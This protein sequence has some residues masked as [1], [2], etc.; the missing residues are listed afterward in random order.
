MWINQLNFYNM[1]LSGNGTGVNIK[2]N[3]G[4]SLNN[5]TFNCVGFE[6]LNTG[7]SIDSKNSIA[8]DIMFNSCRAQEK[9]TTFINATGKV[10]NVLWNGS[11]SLL[12]SNMLNV[13]ND[14]DNWIF[15]NDN[16]IIKILKGKKFNEANSINC[17]GGYK[18]T[19]EDLNTITDIGAYVCQYVDSKNITN[20]PT[21]DISFRLYV[22]EC[23]STNTHDYDFSIMQIYTSIQG[24]FIRYITKLNNE[25]TV[26]K[27]HS[28]NKKPSYSDGTATS[29][30][31]ITATTDCIVYYQ[32]KLTQGMTITINGNDLIYYN[33][34]EPTLIS[35][36]IILSAGDICN[37]FAENTADTLHAKI[38]P[39]K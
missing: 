18:L 34:Q 30:K 39:Y 1:H 4:E 25:I 29:D 16:K 23:D 31:K 35:N 10:I 7:I 17:T 22:I 20:K 21:D 15:Y 5:Y 8:S 6:Q 26:E 13:S 27:W 12:T 14:C 32:I 37:F 38:I 28:L 9:L 24:N 36:S 11:S 2:N 33:I 3:G 19:N